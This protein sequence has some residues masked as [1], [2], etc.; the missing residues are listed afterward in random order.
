MT[1][2]LDQ[3]TIIIPARIQSTRLPEKPLCL[4]GGKPLIYRVWE[5]LQPLNQQGAEIIVA[6]D[7]MKVKEVFNS[8]PCQV[9]MTSSKHQS[10]TERCLEVSEKTTRPYILNVQGD[11]P[12]I[13]TEDLC[14]LSE[15][16]ETSRDDIMGTL[17]YKNKDQE[18]F[19]EPHTVKVT[20]NH[21]KEALYFSRSPIPY[22]P[23][24]NKKFWFYQHLGTYAYSKDLLRSL[25]SFPRGPLTESENLEQLVALENAIKIKCLETTHPSIGIDTPKDLE[26]ANQ[27]FHGGLSR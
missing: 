11:E 27:S 22:H 2:T 6:T 7:S 16:V 4:L 5:N 10:G 21:Q 13:K 3:W 14:S 18:S 24:V 23:Q 19:L 26:R 1:S 15:V 8:T 20:L 12:F 9:M 25:C 17:V